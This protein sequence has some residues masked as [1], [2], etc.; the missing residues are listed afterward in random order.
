MRTLRLSSHDGPGFGLA[1]TIAT[2]VGSVSAGSASERVGLNMPIDVF[3]PATVGR[4]LGGFRGPIYKT[5][6]QEAQIGSATARVAASRPI[7]LRD[8]KASACG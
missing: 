8:P 7:M 1:E 3:Q 6:L 2:P 4:T 5:P